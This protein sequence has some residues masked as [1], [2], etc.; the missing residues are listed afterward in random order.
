MTNSE[1]RQIEDRA[2]EIALAAGEMTL[3]YFKRAFSIEQKIDGSFV[4]AADRAVERFLREEI[5]KDFPDDGILGEEEGETGGKSGRR[6]IIDPIDGTYSFV[7]GVPFYGVLMALESEDRSLIGVINIPALGELVSASEGNGCRFNGAPTRV[8]DTAKL[9]DALLLATD[10]GA[11]AKYGFGRAIEDL[12]TQ[13]GQRRT[14]G[15]CYGYLLVATGRAE[16]MLDPIMNIWDCAALQPVMEEAGGTFTD[17]KGVK[18]ISGGNAIAT[19]GVLYD[20]VMK[21]VS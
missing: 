10:F 18:T 5:A 8:S 20:N 15:D 3:E 19:N 17:W 4:T 13:V 7:H 16:I 6:W 14:W 2:V 9:A 1:L 11:C 12:A 21:I